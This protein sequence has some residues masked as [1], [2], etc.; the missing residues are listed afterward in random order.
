MS[1]NTIAIIG[2]TGNQ[3]QTVITRLLE[4]DILKNVHIRALT[5]DPDSLKSKALQSRGAGRIET[6]EADLNDTDGLNEAL[7][8]ADYVFANLNSWLDMDKEVQQGKNLIDASKKNK[9][10]LFVWSTLPSFAA[11]SKGKYTHVRHAE[12]KALIQEYLRDSGLVW[13]GASTAFFTSNFLLPGY[14]SLREA[15]S[16]TISLNIL[17]AGRMLP[18]TWLEKDL[19]PFVTAIMEAYATGDS[20]VPYNQS[21]IVAGF[22][23]SHAEVAAEISKQTGKPVEIQSQHDLMPTEMS[24]MLE[25]FNELGFY[26]GESVPSAFVQKN[27]IDHS[28]LASFVRE[29]LIP[30]LRARGK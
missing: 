3:G 21:V 5:R 19:G 17:D 15:E 28:T 22:R 2:A 8:G 30:G 12:N 27:G 18:M 13:V 29:A 25:T 6:T 7:A 9:V 11:L 10:K 23:A 14:V 20:N 1:I 24:E 26:E 4:S 16:W